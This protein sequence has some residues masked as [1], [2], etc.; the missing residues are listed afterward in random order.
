M[1][2]SAA[3]NAQIAADPSSS[4]AAGEASPTMDW[5]LVEQ[6]WGYHESIVF[7]VIILIAGYIASK[8]ISNGPTSLLN[9]SKKLDEQVKLLSVRLLRV[10]ILLIT[11][12]RRAW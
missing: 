3:E 10:V 8:V 9:K 5:S 11:L 2:E 6:G 4:T 12:S 1:D 7:S